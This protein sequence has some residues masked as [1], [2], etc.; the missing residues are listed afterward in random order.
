MEVGFIVP[1]SYTILDY[2]SGDTR[3]KAAVPPV[4]IHWM[5]LAY[6]VGFTLLAFHLFAT[7][8]QKG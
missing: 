6:F 2:L 3:G 8:R 1:Y 7:Q 4:N 5:A